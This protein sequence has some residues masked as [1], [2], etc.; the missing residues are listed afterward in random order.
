MP[1]K[2]QTFLKG[3]FGTNKEFLSEGNGAIPKWIASFF[4]PQWA[5]NSKQISL[6]LPLYRLRH[7][8]VSSRYFHFFP[9]F[10]ILLLIFIPIIAA[11]ISKLTGVSQICCIKI[12]GY[13]GRY[14]HSVIPGIILMYAAYGHTRLSFT[15]RF[16]AFL[17]NLLKI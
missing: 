15:P 10:K 14:I 8:L 7:G 6:Q 4:L 2:R 3:Y 11:E 9:F 17:L 16:G 12:R 1:S 5:I 13:Y